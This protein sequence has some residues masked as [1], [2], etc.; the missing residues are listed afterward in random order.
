MNI[1]SILTFSSC[2]PQSSCAISYHAHRP[3]PGEDHRQKCCLWWREFVSPLWRINYSPEKSADPTA[4]SAVADASAL[5]NLWAK[6]TWTCMWMCGQWHAF[7]L[8]GRWSSLPTIRWVLDG[9]ALAVLLTRVSSDV[10]VMTNCLL[11]ECAR[12]G[13]ALH[14]R[15]PFQSEGAGVSGTYANRRGFGSVGLAAR[16]WNAGGFFP[17]VK[18]R[19]GKFPQQKLSIR[20]GTIR[21]SIDS[22]DGRRGGCLFIFAGGT[23]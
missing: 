12:T 3:L 7:R 11:R 23:V 16:W 9:A 13:A 19:T 21:C 17:R 4:G 1:I 2:L 18:S 14:L 10:K 8:R 5:S 15:R 6:C 20:S 22:A